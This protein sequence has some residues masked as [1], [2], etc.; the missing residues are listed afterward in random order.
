[1]SRSAVIA[2]LFLATALLPAQERAIPADKDPVT[3]PQ[4]LKYSV[5]RR[6]DGKVRARLGDMVQ[7]HYT[8]WLENG[9]VFGTSRRQGMAPTKFALVPRGKVIPGWV[10][11]IQ[12]MHVG[13]QFKFT[14]PAS[15]GYGN[16]P[17]ATV[18]SDSTL[19]FEVELVSAE[20]HFELPSF[21]PGIA[22]RQK[23]MESGLKY[24]VIKEG[25]GNPPA[26]G[27]FFELKY[28]LWNKD[29]ILVSCDLSHVDQP[30]MQ[31]I[32]TSPMPLF[33]EAIPLLKP[34][35]RYRFE[36]PSKLCYGGGF[37]SPFLPPNSVTIWELEVVSVLRPPVFSM[38]PKE[39]IKTTESGLQYEVIEEGKGESPL[40][41]SQV[42][43]EYAGWLTDGKLFDSSFQ[44][45]KPATFE[46]GKV[47]KGWSEGL[48][49]MKEGSVY[50]F[51]IPPKLGYADQKLQTIPANSTLV[52]WV[53]LVEVLKK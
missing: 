49:L 48:A 36:A 25:N 6:G 33:G 7:V 44:R 8:G 3:T 43:V 38:S 45:G 47:I 13:D 52:F 26:E 28:A 53:R 15:L 29:G 42:S 4:G 1:V 18:P 9:R 27:E 32:K 40:A 34:G 12:L 30:L 39:K 21:R 37:F 16:K 14:V 17:Q 31:S 5:L 20:R 10:L 35:S 23:T 11:G 46:V 2:I 41:T 22:T 50:K 19:I 51:T 24:E